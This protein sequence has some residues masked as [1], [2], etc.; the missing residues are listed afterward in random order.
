MS[1][2]NTDDQCINV[3]KPSELFTLSTATDTPIEVHHYNTAVVP[4]KS[5]ANENSFFGSE[6]LNTCD[7]QGIVVTYVKFMM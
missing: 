5:H 7:W 2:N 6:G 3:I 1:M 4:L